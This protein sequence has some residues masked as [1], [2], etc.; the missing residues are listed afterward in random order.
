MTYDNEVGTSFEF[1]KGEKRHVIKQ[2][3]MGTLV[4]KYAESVFREL[5]LSLE[6]DRINFEQFKLFIRKHPKLQKS[7]FNS[8]HTETWMCD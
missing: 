8:F 4:R 3:S 5:E 2:A 1:N 7:Y 6:A